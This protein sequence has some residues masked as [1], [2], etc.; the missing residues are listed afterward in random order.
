M[1]GRLPLLATALLLLLPQAATAG[2]WTQP[3]GA[4]WLKLSAGYLRTTE[5]FNHEGE[6]LELLEED[7]GSEDAAF[8]DLNLI[9][10]GEYGLLDAVTLVGGLPLKALRSER[11]GLVGGG[12]LRRQEARNTLGAGD[13]SL[14][15]RIR[16]MARP[17]ALAIQTGLQIPLGYDERPDNDGPPLGSGNPN[18]EIHFLAGVSLYPRP[19]Y[20]TAGVGYRRRGGRLHDEIPFSVEGGWRRGRLLLKLLVQGVRNTKTPPDIFGAPVVTPL[21]GGGGAFPDLVVGDQ[22]ILQVTPAAIWELGS[23]LS[24]QAEIMRT[25][26]G[27][28]TLSGTT[29]SLGLLLRR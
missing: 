28:N 7:P 10:Y 3:K 22:H 14:S 16:L 17:V 24:V 27:T 23:G 21:P 19:A 18:A 1:S 5:E 2:A 6:R 9:L 26:A 15:L 20:L 11:T 13:L 8:R 25:A 29:L 4:L 12:L